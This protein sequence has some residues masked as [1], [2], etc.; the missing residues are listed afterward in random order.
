MKK[1]IVVLLLISVMSA[2]PSACVPE[3][4]PAPTLTPTATRE[5]VPTIATP[6]ESDF[7][8]NPVEGLSKISSWA[9]TYP[10]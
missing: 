4:T 3:Q 9:P 7:H 6:A 1:R 5:P 8:V 2:A 10:C